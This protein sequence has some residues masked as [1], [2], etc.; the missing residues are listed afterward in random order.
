M[1]AGARPAGRE[2]RGKPAGHPEERI[3]L[4]SL[5]TLPTLTTYL[6]LCLKAY[7]YYYYDYY[8]YYYYFHFL[9][10]LTKG[11]PIRECPQGNSQLGNFNWEFPIGNSKKGF[12]VKN[13]QFGIPNWEF[14]MGNSQEPTIQIHH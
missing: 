8:H 10:L 6:T 13:S 1:P 7:E 14:P 2:S 5:P 11:I 12:P 9:L 3:Y 4:S